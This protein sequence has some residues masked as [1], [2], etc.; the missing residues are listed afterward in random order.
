MA[1]N[2]DHNGFHSQHQLQLA[3]AVLLI[4]VARSDHDIDPRERT[5]IVDT[6]QKRFNLT[7]HETRKLVELATT[8]SAELTSYYEFSSLVNKRFAYDEKINLL[9]L[10]W[11]VALT[12][13]HLD[14]YEEHLIRKIANLIYIKREDIVLAKHRAMAS[15]KDSG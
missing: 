12:D 15:L 3:T 9:E 7:P 1:V 8:E 13:G 2:R 14:K 10:M 11:L 4:E 6:I 5:R